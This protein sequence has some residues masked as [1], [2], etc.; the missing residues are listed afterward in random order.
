M[1]KREEII[2]KVIEV[3]EELKS[4]GVFGSEV[5]KLEEILKFLES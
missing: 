5:E 2:N 1:L 3:T 4:W